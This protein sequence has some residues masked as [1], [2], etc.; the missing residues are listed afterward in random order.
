MAKPIQEGIRDHGA[1]TMSEA[2]GTMTS[3]LE[4][5]KPG[6]V[7][8]KEYGNI[9][10]DAGKAE[11]RSF[12]LRHI[13]KQRHDE[14]KPANEMAAL[15]ILLNG[16][17]KNGKK[18]RDIK[19]ARQ[20]DH[21][22]RMELDAGGIVAIVSRQ[23][24]QGDNEQWVL[25]GF[26]DRGNKEAADAIQKVISRYGYA[27]EFLGL[28]KQVGAVVSSIDKISHESIKKSSQKNETAVLNDL[29]KLSDILLTGKTQTVENKDVGAISVDRG[30]LGK[31]GYGLLHIIEGRNIKDRLN[32]D[33]ITAMLYRVVN[34]AEEG[35][36]VDIQPKMARGK[37]TERIGIEKNG[38]IA[39]L[40]KARNGK[41]EKFVITGY[42]MN[43]KKEEATEAIRTVIARY[44]RSPEFSDFR[45]QVGAAVSSINKISHESLKKSSQK[46]AKPI[47]EGIR[48]YGAKIMSEAA[49]T[50]TSVLETGKSRIV[51]HK[52]Y[53]NILVDVGE[54]K[55][56]SFGLKHI[57]KQRHSEG[58]STNEMAALLILLNGTLK[59]GKKMH[60]IKFEKQ[61]EHLGRMKLDA[62]GIIAIVSK[63]REQGDNEQWVLTG[64]D[65]RENKEVADTIQKVISRYGYA[66]EF[67]GLEKQVGAVVSSIDK[68]SHESI[69]KSSQKT[70][71]IG[72]VK[73]YLD[74]VEI[75]NIDDFKY[76]LKALPMMFPSEFGKD[77]IKAA[78]T[79]L[80]NL[81]E[82]TKKA[83]G[84][85]LTELG[86]SNPEKTKEKLDRWAGI[87]QEKNI[88]KKPEKNIDNGMER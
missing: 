83:I 1:K 31:S 52:E 75:K 30:N 81:D 34:A 51:T 2:A 21:L 17:L 88:E 49:K 5:G 57:I 67:L 27:P 45:R 77:S 60:D 84:G 62:G 69:K 40:S 11:S 6:I 73:A 12:G 64:Y 50:M 48:D 55:K 54:A 42:G 38:I 20:P 53:G 79:L 28:E 65:D 18:T 32:N 7:T 47:Q 22:G 70:E 82:N 58:K 43:E 37:D 74:S 8:H 15:L 4:T 24:E 3:V 9:V 36:I 87:G 26:E 68:I 59:N 29:K 85:V 13:I 86:C 61:P 56:R 23:R 66:P 71:K 72:P 44:G 41:D 10:V 46:M 33:E 39:I 35:R 16:T 78:K 14:G 76:Q 63:Q 19:F 80:E 25:T